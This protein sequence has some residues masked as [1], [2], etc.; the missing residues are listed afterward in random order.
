MSN[1]DTLIKIVAPVVTGMGYEFWGCEL[2]SA[3]HQKLRV[4]IDSAKGVD[5][6]DCATV[7]RQVSAVLDVEDPIAGDYVLEI[8]SP[9]I[10]RPLFYIEQ[11]SRYIGEKIKLRLNV[12][13]AGRR[14]FAGQ[15]TA[16][17]GNSI[18]MMVDG[19]SV[20][21]E[22]DNIGRAKLDPVV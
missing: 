21:L 18:S 5:V 9:G 8:S 10:D 14:N 13:Q 2:L 12:P 1:I 19:Q 3:G 20:T 7:S 17:E 22:C 4:Y 15:L 6:E 16:V 11:F